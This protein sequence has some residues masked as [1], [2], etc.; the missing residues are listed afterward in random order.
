MRPARPRGIRIEQSAR[1]GGARAAIDA[2]GIGHF[3]GP[4][5]AHH[6]DLVGHVAHHGQIV[7]DE[8]ISHTEFVLQIEQ[9]VEHLCL[10]RHIERRYGLITD[11][12]IRPQR[13][14]TC[15]RDAL[16]LAPGEFMRIAAQGIARQADTLQQL[17]GQ[18]QACRCVR[19]DAVQRH[20][21]GQYVA[22]W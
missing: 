1:I 18:T 7:G 4:A 16:T 3:D 13:Q 11:E 9:Q 20:R 22:Q 8:D 5:L 6:H 12:H 14:A 2:L 10:D 15:N 19:A 21:F 17:G